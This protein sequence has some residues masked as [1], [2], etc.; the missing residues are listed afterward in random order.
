M[1]ITNC[2]W[3]QVNIGKRTVEITVEATD[4]FSLDMLNNACNGYD[5]L[6]VKV[7]MNKP[8]FNFGLSNM[9]FT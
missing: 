8:S 7:P 6:V 4:S 2:F 3:E 9:G 1:K 5:Y